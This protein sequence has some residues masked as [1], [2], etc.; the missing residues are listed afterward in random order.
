MAFGF[1]FKL[2]NFI[3]Y[4]SGSKIE[5]EAKSKLEEIS[6]IYCK[7][8]NLAIGTVYCLKGG[9]FDKLEKYKVES[10]NR[11]IIIRILKSE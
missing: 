1:E 5:E 6:K 7:K 10:I 2:P 9:K 8:D 11:R 4:E 3:Y